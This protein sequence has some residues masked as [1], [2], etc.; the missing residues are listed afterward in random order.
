MLLLEP[1]RV[2]TVE[3]LVDAVWDN[4]PPPT[5]KEQ[6][7][8]CVSFIRRA[9]TG[10]G[11]P[12]AIVTRPPG[13]SIQCTDHELDLLEFNDLVASG[14]R[15]LAQ[16]RPHDAADT[17]RDALRLWR[18]AVPLAGVRSQ[19]VQ[20]IGTQLAE[21]RLAVIEE[22]VD[23]RLR[24]GQHHELT[25]GLAELVAANPFR[26]RLRARLMI[27]LYQGGRQAEAL[28]TYRVGRQLF[29]EQL[30]LEPGVELRRL[31]RAILAGEVAD[32]LEP[33]EAS[34]PVPVRPAAPRL[35]PADIGDFTGRRD[36]IERVRA[37][38]RGPR[39]TGSR[40][41][42]VVIVTGRP[43]LGKTTLAVHVAHALDGEYPDGQ[44]FARLGGAA[45]PADAEGVLARFLGALGVPG[46]AVPDTLEE[47]T[48]MYRNLLS[49]RRILVVLD[50]AG[51]GQQVAPLLPGSP[52][53]SVILTS[54]TRLAVLGGATTLGVDPLDTQESVELLTRA[55]GQER[56]D[57]KAADIALLADLCAGEP[58]ALRLAAER[59]KSQPHLPVRDLIVRLYDDRRRLTELSYGGLDLVAMVDEIWQG[60]SP[61]ARRLLRRVS[62]LDDRGFQG[63]MCAPLLDVAEQDAQD[64]LTE[65]LG[66]GLLDIERQD[67]QVV[68]QLRGLLQAFVRRLAAEDS[69]IGDTGHAAEQPDESRDTAVPP[70]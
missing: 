25:S 50:D 3:R 14:R 43:W 2:V 33:E 28:H 23:V 40:A 29:V 5:A 26:E 16:G 34:R 35:L 57:I 4:T 22:Y 62:R 13:Y 54:R 12:D 10:G 65:L 48:D 39:D 41:V 8:I 55:V 52:T 59:L 64:A 6:V 11:R 27:A 67:G 66:A 47:R 70:W 53:C 38:L 63:W 42:P 1:N 32:L 68:F 19:L 44:L 15:L 49:D 17:L 69:L 21:R 18:G 45:R 9:L 58:L 7:R 61:L 31:E 56:G 46:R 30:G 51:G 37:A 36:L 20:S 60:L 24:L